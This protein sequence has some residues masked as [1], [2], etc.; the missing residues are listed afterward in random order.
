MAAELDLQGADRRSFVGFGEFLVAFCHLV[1]R[2]DRFFAAGGG[3]AQPGG[4]L[5]GPFFR[6][7]RPLGQQ[8]GA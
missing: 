2:I 4:D 5:Y 7:A 8:R 3:L 6:P 1:D